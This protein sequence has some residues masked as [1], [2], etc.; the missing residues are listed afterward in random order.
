M[1]VSALVIYLKKLIFGLFNM[2]CKHPEDESKC[3][4]KIEVSHGEWIG[5]GIDAQQIDAVW[6]ECTKCGLQRDYDPLDD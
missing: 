1:V 5:Y 4:W 3:N 6:M 2:K